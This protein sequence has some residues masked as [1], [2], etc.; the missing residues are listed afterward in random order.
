M[1]SV[2]LIV[3]EGELEA[4]A[5]IRILEAIG[6]R[7]DDPPLV[8]GGTDAFWKNAP[9]YNRA[10]AHLGLVLGLTD[11]EQHSCAPALIAKKVGERLHPNFL[12]RIQVRE[13]ESWLL[14]DATGWA[15]FLNVSEALVP[16][17]PDE[18]PDPKRALVTLARHCR[19]RSLTED[20]V[21]EEGRPATV[22]PGYTPRVA[23][24]IRKTW[25][26]HRAAERSPSLRRAIA[27]L[28][29]ART[30]SSGSHP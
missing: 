6:L 19:R 3:A 15:R 20:L 21:P 22:G 4:V 7:Y 30:D 26:P 13:L 9:R 23:E 28:Q 17:A 8:Q 24:F 16:K 11:L 5:A 10:A 14:A 27:A 29:R 1:A 12:L 25:E 18:L 2:R